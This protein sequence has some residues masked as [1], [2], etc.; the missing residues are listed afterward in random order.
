MNI[1]YIRV[2][3][4]DGSQTFDLQIDA[5]KKV[6]IEKTPLSPKKTLINL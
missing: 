3:K 2:S 6:G 4:A 5:L 1:D